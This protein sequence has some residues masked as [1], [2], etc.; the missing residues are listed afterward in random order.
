MMVIARTESAGQPANS[1]V[2]NRKSVGGHMVS[3]INS[4][5]FVVP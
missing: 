4:N 1:I 2:V 5:M 3:S